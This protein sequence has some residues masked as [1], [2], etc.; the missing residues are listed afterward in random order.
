MSNELVPI[1][2]ASTHYFKNA[3]SILSGSF[4][5]MNNTQL[6]EAY[7]NPSSYR[8]TFTFSL[9]ENDQVR[10]DII[11]STGYHRQNID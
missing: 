9:A 6:G 8:T 5:L 10:L 7:P 11:N 2:G 1:E 4:S 3:S